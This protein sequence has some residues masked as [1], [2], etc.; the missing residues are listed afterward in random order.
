MPGVSGFLDDIDP[1][2]VTEVPEAVKLWFLSQLPPTS[3]DS[4]CI[5]SLPHLEFRLRLAQAH[6]ALDLIRCLCGVY[7]ALLVKVQVHVSN[8]QGM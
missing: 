4:S 3:R 6:D 5:D 2:A 1:T 8:S 7:Q